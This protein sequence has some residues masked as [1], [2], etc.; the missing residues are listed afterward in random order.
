M[1]LHRPVDSNAKS[2]IRNASFSPVDAGRDNEPHVRSGMVSLRRPSLPRIKPTL[3]FLCLA[4][5]AVGTAGSAMAGGMLEVT[6]TVPVARSVGASVNGTISIT[7]DR[8]VDPAT[9]IPMQSVWAFGRWSGTVAG[10]LSL[11]NGN[12]TINLSPSEPLS[13]G[14]NVMVLLSNELRG[15]DGSALRSGGYTFQFWTRAGEA[16]MDFDLIQTIPTLDGSRPYGGIGTDMNNDRWLDLTMVNEDTADLR[17]FL[18]KADG[19][20]MFDSMVDPP[21]GVGL[22]ASPSDPTDFNRDG[23]ADI[24]VANIS[25]NTV[26]ILLGQGDGSFSPQQQINVGSA[27]RGIAVL[28]IDGDGD[29]D[30]AN[31]NS[32]GSG[33]ISFLINDGTGTFAA[34]TFMEAGV[35]NEWAMG[36]ADMNN[37]GLLDLV[38]SGRVTEEIAVLA[39]NGDGTFS[40]VYTGDSGGQV[41]M[42]V[43]G[44]LNADGNEDLTTANSGSNTGSVLLGN[45]SGQLAAP[46]TSPTDNFPLATDLGDIDGDQD[47][48]WVVSSFGGDWTMFLNDGSG[49]MTLDREFPS[50]SNASCALML[51]IDN[52][53]DLDLALIDEIVDVV[54]VYSNGGSSAAVPAVGTWGV[55]IT[56]LSITALGVMISGSVPAGR[57]SRKKRI[58]GQV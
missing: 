20:G 6:S 10:S 52:D 21:A 15:M 50:P 26:S 11:T 44:D 14:E 39:N 4:M 35:F 1:H 36:A 40:N 57:S 41:W 45:G 7:F 3:W 47:L 29:L 2:D 8:A 31:T 43:L 17:V 54:D 13:A 58:H 49:V 25:V 46:V 55:I 18:N 33:S 37:D 51:D 5:S 24:C 16:S 23:N 48:D 27:P 30:I 42:L 22:Q 19:S 9:V 38:V 34:P 56:A 53:S 32:G 28:D 12:T